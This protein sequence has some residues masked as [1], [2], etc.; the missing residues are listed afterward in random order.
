MSVNKL[1]L[2]GRV[3]KDVEARTFDNNMKAVNFTLATNE[4]YKDKNGEKQ[5]IVEWHNIS[6][7]GNLAE[8]AEKY[9]KKGDLLY[10]EGKSKTRSWET[11]EGERK[12]MTE[13]VLTSF[14]GNMR[15]LGRKNESKPSQENNNQPLAP[16]PDDNLPF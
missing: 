14:D 6:I 7:I 16:E 12:Y 10:L 9:V 8:I 3:G 15:M 2:V 13:C 1:T 4:T 5:E 11:K